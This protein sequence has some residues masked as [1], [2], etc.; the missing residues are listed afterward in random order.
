MEFVLNRNNKILEVV[1]KRKG[2]EQGEI[3]LGTVELN[4]T[5]VPEMEAVLNGTKKPDDTSYLMIEK[6]QLPEQEYPSLVLNEVYELKAAAL[7]LAGQ[8]IYCFDLDFDGVVFEK[9][10]SKKREGEDMILKNVKLKY[11]PEGTFTATEVSGI[12]SQETTNTEVSV[13]T[14]DKVASV[15]L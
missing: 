2:E 12:T 3:R 11:L 9:I 8:N 13:V 14:G 7:S 1:I 10:G 15:T 5:Y 6:M 4:Q